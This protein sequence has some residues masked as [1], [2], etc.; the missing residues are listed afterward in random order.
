MMPCLIDD[1]VLA[2]EEAQ[3]YGRVVEVWAPTTTTKVC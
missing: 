1:A 3:K 2:I